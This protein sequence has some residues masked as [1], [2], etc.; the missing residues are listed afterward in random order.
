MEDL[1]RLRLGVD[2]RNR[3]AVVAAFAITFANTA[4]W[5]GERWAAYERTLL[6]A[7]YLD[8]VI[9]QPVYVLTLWLYRWMVSDEDDG[10]AVHEVHPVPGHVVQLDEFGE[11]DE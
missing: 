7:L 8:I 4:P 2:C 5:C 10:R 3:L 1:G 6:A 9:V 11:V